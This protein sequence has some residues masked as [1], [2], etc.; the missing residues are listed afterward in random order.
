MSDSS[1]SSP[2]VD[3]S[4]ELD[5]SNLFLNLN[6]SA[7]EKENIKS[8][9]KIKSNKM[10]QIP[11]FDVKNLCIVPTF[12]GKPSEL[13]EY[14]TVSAVLLNHYYDP[15]PESVGCLQNTLLLHGLK[16]KLTGRA[17]EVISIH[18]VDKW[19]D[20]KNILI[21]HFGDQRNEN[22]LTRDLVNLRQQINETPIKFY[23]KVM[24]VLNILTNYVD[25]HNDNND[26][27]KSKKEF[28]RQQALTTFLAGLREPL[29]ST[30]RAMR[31]NSLATAMQYIQEE[32][33]IY[34]L[35]RNQT[36]YSQSLRN[37]NS[38]PKFVPPEMQRFPQP[39]Q[40]QQYRLPFPREPIDLPPRVNQPQ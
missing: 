2:F 34:Y 12:D 36:P 27:K 25:L 11:T 13:N 35:Q 23:E 38:K 14:L 28:F 5:L 18:G 20:V 16:G 29:G 21:Q 37:E 17:K 24:G 32:N 4:A 39:F 3:P 26:I 10:A 40:T 9:I 22:T 30:I 1:V 6:I 8:E 7:E 15:R 31:P 19:D 33:N